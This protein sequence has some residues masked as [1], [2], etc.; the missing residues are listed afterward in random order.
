MNTMSPPVPEKS[1]KIPMPSAWIRKMRAVIVVR[2]R[3]VLCQVASI[4]PTRETPPIS[5]VA[6]AASGVEMP[7]PC[8]NGTSWIM[9]AA[10]A[11]CPRT[12]AST[13]CQNGQVRQALSGGRS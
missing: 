11:S 6:V 8:R 13:S 2:V 5:P 9:T 7:R 1:N 4:R 12:K 3:A 10:I